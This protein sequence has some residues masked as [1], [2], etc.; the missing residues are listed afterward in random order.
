MFQSQWLSW[1]AGIYYG[2]AVIIITPY[3][4]APIT[5]AYLDEQYGLAY[6]CTV[7]PSG[8]RCPVEHIFAQ[9]LSRDRTKTIAD[10]SAILSD[11]L[12]HACLHASAFRS[13]PAPGKFGI[14]LYCIVL[15]C[16]VLYCIVL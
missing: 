7:P 6:G 14:V 13:E 3:L 11:A 12:D 9:I 16:I 2:I 10:A 1:H 4:P 5:I 8:D 15:Y